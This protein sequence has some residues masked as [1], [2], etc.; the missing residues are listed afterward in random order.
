MKHSLNTIPMDDSGTPSLE[1]HHDLSA[2]HGLSDTPRRTNPCRQK[3]LL[4]TSL[5]LSAGL[6]CL[7]RGA[8]PQKRPAASNTPAPPGGG[9]PSKVYLVAATTSTT[10]PSVS[11]KWI[12]E[13]DWLPPEGYLLF[14]KG[15]QDADF[16]QVAGPLK[17][18]PGAQ[19]LPLVRM[20]GKQRSLP[21]AQTLDTARTKIQLSPEKAKLT[22]LRSENIPAATQE[23]NEFRDL[24]R[25]LHSRPTGATRS[26][27]SPISRSAFPK[28]RHYA[29]QFEALST[30]PTMAS[31]ATAGQGR[32]SAASSR[33]VQPAPK[34]QTVKTG[35]QAT[36]AGREPV[37]RELPLEERVM[38]TRR[39]LLLGS[40]VT[41]G[42]NSA[43]GLGYVDTQVQQGIAYS[44]QL[45]PAS[46]GSPVAQ[47]V[48]TVGSDPA[49]ATPTGLSA[50]QHDETTACLR[51]D[52]DHSQTPG[53]VIAYDIYRVSGG[54]QTKLN[55]EPLVVGPVKSG[56][57]KYVDQLWYFTDNHVP[58][59]AHV[60]KLVGRDAFGRTTPSAEC[61][62]TME[63]WATPFA[64]GETKAVHN[65][66]TVYISWDPSNKKGAGKYIVAGGHDPDA[67]YNV[68]RCEVDPAAKTTAKQPDRTTASSA[69]LNLYGLG[70][71]PS[72]GLSSQWVQ[73]NS[74]P[75]KVTSPLPE[76]MQSG[77]RKQAG[78]VSSVL[79]DMHLYVDKTVVKDHYY[80]YCVTACY[81][82]NG[83]ESSPGPKVLVSVPDLAPPPAPA[84]A[85]A[86]CTPLVQPSKGLELDAAW[87]KPYQIA[88]ARRNK[89]QNLNANVSRL[90]ARLVKKSGGQGSQGNNPAPPPEPTVS[91]SDVGSK[92]GLSWTASTLSGPVRYRVYRAVTTGYWQ[93][94]EA[95]ALS[96]GTGAGAKSAQTST[97][98]SGKA[99]LPGVGNS[100]SPVKILSNRFRY[101]KRVD[102][103]HLRNA[104]Y[105][106]MA[107]VSGNT[108]SDY[109]PRSR[110]MYCAYRIT[111]VNRWGIEGEPRHTEVY[112]PG[113]LTPPTP[114][115]VSAAPNVT[116][117]VTLTW[118]AL[119][120][121]DNCVKYLV[122]R[123]QLDMA[124]LAGA[125]LPA[126]SGKLDNPVPGEEIQ[127][128]GPAASLSTSLPV[129][130]AFITGPVEA[131]D[132]NPVTA[133]KVSG[134]KRTESRKIATI[135]RK[136]PRVVKVVNASMVQKDGY[137]LVGEVP[138]STAN[139]AGLV[140]YN[141]EKNLQPFNFYLYT[142]VAVD[143]DSWLSAAGKPLV[144]VTWKAKSDPAKNF[145][146]E[147]DATGRGV[148]LSWLKPDDDID[149]YIVKRGNSAGG[150][151]CQVSPFLQGELTFTD[152]GALRGRSSTYQLFAIDL[153]G[154]LSDPSTITFTLPKTDRPV[155]MQENRKQTTPS[156]EKNKVPK[157]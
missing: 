63:D 120:D 84:G 33:T 86:K 141:D 79:K 2:I 102:P 134:V 73:L 105:T 49:P 31:P 13:D 138:A 129:M 155:D 65:N 100:K 76:F 14:R 132:K 107:E 36:A 16:I 112:V 34:A 8:P 113:T 151:F 117:G 5:I 41:P 101:L 133:R 23:F 157:I 66:G 56:Q 10:S 32:R 20:D 39:Q 1:S 37:L 47:C 103:A 136:D 118:N 64:P 24:R 114:Q 137:Q 38:Q 52:L 153:Q 93:E 69:L 12:I 99:V 92:V 150:P 121:E 7:A 116:G 148:K 140:S 57:G 11:L 15:P 54:K 108:F 123:Q 106:F 75:I 28:L 143:E 109:L 91:N 104:D 68:Y 142:V 46:G 146:A 154:N 128:S 149:G 9:G 124:K 139:Q 60:Y 27:E 26:F 71:A 45:R 94:Q 82:R 25:Q 110:A 89:V 62:F 145:R 67:V 125:I 90:Q 144:S 19:P 42:V 85:Q 30:H 74:Q 122:Y 51:W 58:V 17:A 44:Y 130:T 4:L 156:K 96:A 29:V 35:A 152:F 50:L 95:A 72:S 59:G 40:L 87:S 22:R 135:R 3:R 111:V 78:K 70:E 80:R 18:N 53:R 131:I 97:G 81:P 55:G 127:D 88:R 126:L 98:G 21:L 61:P 115:L 48:I 6:L 77:D 147:A 119:A 43:V 83:L